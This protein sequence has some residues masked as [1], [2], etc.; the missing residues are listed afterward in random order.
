MYKLASK[1]LSMFWYAAM[2]VLGLSRGIQPLSGAWKPFAA[3]ME[4]SCR[5]ESFD[6]IGCRKPLLCGGQ[7]QQRSKVEGA[8]KLFFCLAPATMD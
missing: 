5:T 7:E 2:V 8:R 3:C 4:G 6:H 1:K